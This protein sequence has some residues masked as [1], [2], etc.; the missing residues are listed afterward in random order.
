MVGIPMG[1]GGTMPTRRKYTDEELREAVRTSTSRR[2]VLLKLG[3]APQGG[4]YATTKRAI[5]ALDLDTS[6]FLPPAGHNKG[7]P[8]GPKRPIE[9]YFENKI[10]VRTSRLRERLILEGY[11]EHQCS[12]CQRRTWLG[13]PIPLELDHIDGNSADNRLGNLRLLCPNCHAQTPTYRR[14]KSSLE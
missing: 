13:S 3:L 9:D 2:Q 5:E 1:Y 11:A 14:R 12:G 8:P 10:T 7:I 4:N 6:H